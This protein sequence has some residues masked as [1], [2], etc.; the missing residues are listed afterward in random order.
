MH[1]ILDAWPLVRYLQPEWRIIGDGDAPRDIGGAWHEL[2]VPGVNGFP[3]VVAAL[4]FWGL[5]LGSAWRT[6]PSWGMAVDDVYFVLNEL[7]GSYSNYD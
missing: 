6:S 5:A 1:R 7:C 3:S 4:Y 2:D